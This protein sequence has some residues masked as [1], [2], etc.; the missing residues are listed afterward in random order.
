[1]GIATLG[2]TL[3]RPRGCRLPSIINKSEKILRYANIRWFE[4]KFVPFVAA[5]E[6]S[7]TSVAF[8]QL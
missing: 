8:I 6:D 2:A 7:E 4:V 1:M 3:T 5:V